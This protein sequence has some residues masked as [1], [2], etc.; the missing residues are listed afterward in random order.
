MGDMGKVKFGKLII[1]AIKICEIRN[2]GKVKFGQL[3]T[4]AKKLREMGDMGKVKFGQLII[5]EAIKLC[6][7]R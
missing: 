5:P 3:I 2:M 1:K 7:M 6:E 4:T